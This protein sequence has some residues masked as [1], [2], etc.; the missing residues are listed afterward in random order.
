MKVNFKIQPTS[1]KEVIVSFTYGLILVI[2]YFINL[3]KSK[4]LNVINE[5]DCVTD[6]KSLFMSN[7]VETNLTIL[8]VNLF[9]LYSLSHIEIIIG[10]ARFFVLINMSI[11]LNTILDYELHKLNDALGC[12]AG[13]SG[14]I[15]SLIVWDLIVSKEVSIFIFIALGLILSTYT[16][17]QNNTSLINH[18]VGAFTGVLLAFIFKKYI[19]TDV[20]KLIKKTL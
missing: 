1:I 9:S 4:S 3:S 13:F 12:S 18:S 10:S 5:K 16:L 20:Q 14:I 11:I 6:L 2:V 15:F 17:K 8:S 19:P 7:F